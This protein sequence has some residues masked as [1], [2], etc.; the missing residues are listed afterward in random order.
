MNL[1]SPY[2]TN[3]VIVPGSDAIYGSL[4]EIACPSDCILISAATIKDI[5]IIDSITSSAL[6]LSASIITTTS[7]V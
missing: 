3:F 7:G 5:E 4:L 2:I 6:G 1:M